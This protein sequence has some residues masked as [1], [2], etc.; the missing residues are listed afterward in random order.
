MAFSFE[1]FDKVAYDFGK[2]AIKLA[3]DGESILVNGVSYVSSVYKEEIKHFHEYEANYKESLYKHILNE[4]QGVLT[5][6]PVVAPVVKV[7]PVTEKTKEAPPV[8]VPV[9]VPADIPADIP[10]DDP[11]PEPSPSS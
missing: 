6:A 8:D 10:A 9:D 5:Q 2:E 7:A 11:V 1:L 3:E 4:L